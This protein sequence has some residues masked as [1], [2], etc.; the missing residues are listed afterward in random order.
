MKHIIG[1]CIL[2]I[3]FAFISC[4]LG[5]DNGSDLVGTWIVKQIPNI[6]YGATKYI[7]Y[8][9]GTGK[10]G[11]DDILWLVNIDNLNKTLN[12]DVEYA[13]NAYHVFDLKYYFNYDK[14]VLYL[15]SET[16]GLRWDTWIKK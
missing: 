8:D 16:K 1:L 12:I 4:N 10:K 14:S 6:T 7:F 2:I 5:L 13:E 15:Q 9:D 11:S 3:F